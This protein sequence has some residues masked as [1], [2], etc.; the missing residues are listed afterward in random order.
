MRLAMFD[1]RFQRG[2]RVMSDQE[3]QKASE[4]LKLIHGIDWPLLREE[5]NYLLYHNP[6]ETVEVEGLLGLIDALQ[7]FA[8]DI[9]G[10]PES[11]VFAFEGGE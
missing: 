5:K 3:M 1:G 2:G 4:A 11:E 8:T 10:V 6:S 7:D 9:L